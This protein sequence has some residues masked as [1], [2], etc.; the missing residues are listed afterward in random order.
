M[1]QDQEEKW[2]LVE[3]NLEESVFFAKP[4][5]VLEN[6]KNKE[7]VRLYFEE[8]KM[9]I[10]SVVYKDDEMKI[11]LL[12]KN[13]KLG[14][15]LDDLNIKPITVYIKESDYRVIANVNIKIGDT[16]RNFTFSAISVLC[17]IIASGI[18]VPIFI[19]ETFFEKLKSEKRLFH[20]DIYK[21]VRDLDKKLRE[22]I[23]TQ[24]LNKVSQIQDKIFN[25]LENRNN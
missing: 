18:D 12:P 7:K 11:D 5:I 2:C 21:I 6:V 14:A 1:Y 24:D 20:E 19:E 22:T 13:P 4:F 23:E 16:I 25:I 8:I 3:I 10:T 15:L 17:F 9:A